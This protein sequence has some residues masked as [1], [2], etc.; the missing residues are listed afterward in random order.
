M[1]AMLDDLVDGACSVLEREYLR[2]E[3]AHGLPSTASGAQRQRRAP[4]GTKR[5]YRD[6]DYVE[7]G[8]VVELDGLA[9]HDSASVRDS[10]AERDLAHAATEDGT[11]VRLTH[12]LVFRHGCQSVRSVAT[13]LQRRGWRGDFIR[14][15]TAS[16]RPPVPPGDTAGRVDGQAAGRTTT[17]PQALQ[18]PSPTAFVARTRQWYA[19]AR[20]QP[21]HRQSPR[22]PARRTRHAAVGAPALHAVARHRAATARRRGE[23]HPHRPRTRQRLG[24]RRRARH[25][26]RH[27]HRL[28]VRAPRPVADRVRRPH[29][30]PVALA[31]RQ[32][33]HPELLR[34]P[35]RRTG[36]AAVGARAGRGVR[37]DGLPPS[38]PDLKPTSTSR[39]RPPMSSPSVP[40]RRRRD[41]GRRASR[42]PGAVAAPFVPRTRHR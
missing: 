2:L 9:F 40:P 36:R 42:S 3:R 21:A 24:H 7:Y 17:A 23:R 25:R 26:R 31:R 22:R 14:C 19:L 10:D 30:A 39:R 16:T 20:R 38:A 5:G 6:V 12:G 29:P 35:A 15:P 34:R 1:L 32:P 41:G 18:A 33:A 13:I 11:T 37:R 27:D 4:I 28:A 8:V